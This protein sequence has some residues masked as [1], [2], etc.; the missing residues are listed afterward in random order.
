MTLRDGELSFSKP[1]PQLPEMSLEE[2]MAAD[3]AYLE[4]L[5]CTDEMIAEQQAELDGKEG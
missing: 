2:R 1:P 3:A 5:R 4:S